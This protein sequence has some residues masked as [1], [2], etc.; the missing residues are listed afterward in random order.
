MA[1][2]TYLND[3][4]LRARFLPQEPDDENTLP[5][6]ETGGAQ[7]Y[8]YWTAEGLCVSVHLDTG[9]IPEQL[10]DVDGTIPVHVTV[11]GDTVFAA[12]RAAAA[13][14]ETV[15]CL[16]CDTC[17]GPRGRKCLGCDEPLVTQDADTAVQFRGEDLHKLAEDL[18]V[19]VAQLLSYHDVPQLSAPD[20]RAFL[21][22]C[23]ELAPAPGSLYYPSQG[24]ADD[25][26]SYVAHEKV[27]WRPRES[28]D[29]D[30][31][32]AW[33][34]NLETEYEQLREN[35]VGYGRNKYEA[36]RMALRNE[37]AAARGLDDVTRR[38]VYETISGIEQGGNATF[39]ATHRGYLLDSRS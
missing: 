11:N 27:D 28:A 29:E 6:I 4:N 7:V 12:G 5:C 26:C 2:R 3:L 38:E 35:R 33:R 18:G 19:S 30:A 31:R 37:R 9:E 10:Y 34:E 32:K 25:M 36:A 24:M 20:D 39:H 14:Q 17:N 21:P 1:D 23:P 8:A 15:P 13:E 16:N 22:R